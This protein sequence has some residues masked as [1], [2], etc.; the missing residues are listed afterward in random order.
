MATATKEPALKVKTR[1][2]L[3]TKTREKM[4]DEIN[5]RIATLIDLQLQVKQ[6][7]WNIRGPQFIAIHEMLDKL[8][9]DL[10][11]WVDAMAERI[12]QLGGA[13][14][15]TL[16]AIKGSSSLDKYPTQDLTWQD[17]MEHLADVIAAS[18]TETRDSIE[19]AEDAGDPVSGD[20]IT[21]AAR[22]LD[23]WLWK[24]ESHLDSN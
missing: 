19:V 20:I 11:K 21:D 10:D 13:A 17:R 16:D 9:A 5:A 4:S 1:N 22:G 3:P 8:Y 15:G 7:H 2:T 12:T 14:Y 23:L 24:V 6:T 18:S